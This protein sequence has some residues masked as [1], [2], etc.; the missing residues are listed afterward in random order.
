MW[1]YDQ[2]SG[3]L[4]R[5]GVLVCVGYSG[6]GEGKNN[7]LMQNLPRV[8]PIPRGMYLIAHARDSEMHGPFVL[9]ILPV[10]GTQTFGRSG[11]LIH[12]DSKEHLGE[13]SLGCIIA[14]RP[15]REAID[16]SEDPQLLVT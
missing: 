9:P 5:N 3:K 4:S 12:G 1:T 11:F 7:P 16:A 15:V 8:G 14:P 6:H 13:A 10:A 2:I